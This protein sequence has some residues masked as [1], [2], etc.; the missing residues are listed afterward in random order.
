MQNTK[1]TADIIAAYVANNR[2]EPD[3]LPHLI[4]TIHR[5]ISGLGMPEPEAAD[6]PTPVTKAQIRNSIRPDSL[7][8]FID[9]KPYKLLK[10]HL[11]KLGFTPEEYCLRFGLPS[12]YPMVAADYTAVRSAWAK[13]NGLGRTAKLT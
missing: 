13:K 11:T 7:V 5:A 1:I 4:G 3:A 9:G 8:S 12:D 10:R 2:V 6:A